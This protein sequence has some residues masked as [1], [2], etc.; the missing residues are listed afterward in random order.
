MII[1]DG[2]NIPEELR[3]VDEFGWASI[4]ASTKRTVQGKFIVQQS[5]V[6]S[7]SGRNITLMSDNAWADRATVLI[8]RNWTDELDKQL[9]LQLNDGRSFLCRF[10][11]WDM[12]CLEADD[13]IE[14]AF[15]NDDTLYKVTLKLAVV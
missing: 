15:P 14:S 11:H 3:W 8:L 12:P 1:L 7:D 2:M 6:P 5:P 10:R 9:G 4:K 13:L